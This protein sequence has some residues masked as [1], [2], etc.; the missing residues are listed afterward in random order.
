ME[1]S[2]MGTGGF[3]SSELGVLL[4]RTELCHLNLEGL[5]GHYGP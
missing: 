1:I 5:F 3:S 4:C 2:R